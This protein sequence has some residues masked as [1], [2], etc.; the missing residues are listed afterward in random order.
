MGTLNIHCFMENRKDTPKLFPFASYGALINSQWLE[1]SL[2]RTN[3][4][5]PKD[6]RT[7]KFDYITL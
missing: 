1:L 6:V 3:F 2:S 7:L 5:G 4:H